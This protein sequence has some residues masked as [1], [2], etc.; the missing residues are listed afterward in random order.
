MYAYMYVS[1][2]MWMCGSED[3]LWEWV[4]SFHPVGS[5]KQTPLVMFGSNCLYSGPRK[6]L[7]C[8]VLFCFVLFFKSDTT[9]LY[10][11]ITETPLVS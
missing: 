2:V 4:F 6:I 7:F 8:F 3:N 9:W 5:T 10:F 11:N 1:A